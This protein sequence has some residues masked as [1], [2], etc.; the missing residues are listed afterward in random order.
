MWCAE[1]SIRL[2]AQDEEAALCGLTNC[3]CMEWTEPDSEIESAFADIDSDGNPRIVNVSV[4][5]SGT[6]PQLV[7]EYEAVPEPVAS[8]D[9]YEIIDIL[10]GEG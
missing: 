7:F 2:L 9:P 6:K 3:A 8:D 4:D 1:G 10:T 5:V